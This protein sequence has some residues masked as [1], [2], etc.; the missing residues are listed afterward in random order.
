MEPSSPWLS[1]VDFARFSVL[2]APRDSF[3]EASVPVA[4]PAASAVSA[5]PTTTS[6]RPG[7]PPREPHS[8]ARMGVDKL[9]VRASADTPYDLDTAVPA[10]VAMNVDDVDCTWFGAARPLS[11]TPA[12]QTALHGADAE[13][14][15][16]SKLRHFQQR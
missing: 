11:E 8:V 3:P 15:F 13:D 12:I 7:R 5:V 1:T 10:P 4:V 14:S 6:A 16:A 9:S 2:H